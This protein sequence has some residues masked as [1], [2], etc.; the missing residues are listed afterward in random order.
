METICL[1]TPCVEAG[2]ARYSSEL[3]RAMRAADRH[4]RFELITSCN[5]G[6]EFSDAPYRINAILP[7]LRHRSSFSNPASW[8]VN[9]LTHY[10]RRELA[11]L[12]W[13]A[14]RADVSAVHFQ[15]WTP[16]LAAP[17]FR[18]VRAMGKRVFFTV[19][20]ILP[21]RYPRGIPRAALHHMVRRGCRAA[22]GLFV[23]TSRLADE[24]SDFL[25]QRHPPIHVTPHG[26][27]NVARSHPAI[28]LS[29]RLSRRKLLFFGQLRRNKGLD[30]FLRAAELLEGFSVTIAGEWDD[31][32][33]WNNEIV[34]LIQRLRS[35]GT[36]IDLKE[37]YVPESQVGTLF[38][39]H[40]AV[41]L[42]YTQQFVAQSGVIFMALAYGLPVVASEMGGLGELLREHAIGTTFA[43]CTPGALADAIN[44]LWKTPVAKLDAA[45]ATARRE[46]S[47]DH[48]ARATLAGYQS[49]LQEEAQHHD[50]AVPTTATV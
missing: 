46:M 50:A 29:N 32:A 12:R 44:A 45:I 25:Q 2:H 22:D 4:R 38:E 8:V 21:H 15:E 14:A 18:R 30:L 39:T 43:E 17:A 10:P 37:G 49:V 11:L 28:D 41:V 27:W 33:Y 1:F 42:P 7:A 13:L 6:S 3:L 23:H 20:N 5:L 31:A 35:R 26:V 47:W 34:P 40:S 36:P 19:H 48:T 16:W 9:R 24:L